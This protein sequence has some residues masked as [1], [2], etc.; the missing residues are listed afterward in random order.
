MPRM[1]SRLQIVV[2]VASAM[3]AGAAFFGCGSSKSRSSGGNGG[4]A[5]TDGSTQGSGGATGTGATTANGGV[6]G[7]GSGGIGSGGFGGIAVG[8]T[9][10]D[11]AVNGGAGGNVGVGGSVS[12][13]SGGSAGS[14]GATAANSCAVNGPCSPSAPPCSS[15][16]KGGTVQYACQ[17]TLKG[18]GQGYWNCG[19][20]LPCGSGNYGPSGSTC[21]PRFQTTGTYCD[22]AGTK[23]SC[24]CQ[25]S[26]SPQPGVWVCSP[27][28][29]TCGVACGARTCLEGEICVSLGQYSGTDAGSSAPTLTSICAAI[30]DACAGTTPSCSACIISAFGCG[31]PGTCRDVSPQ[32]FECI[33]GGA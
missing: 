4:A 30:P 9:G 28:L 20:V 2:A 29:G 21:D 12:P 32:S 5:G 33:L 15:C 8:G 7:T 1:A 22:S 23:Q 27:G 18:A 10:S 16:A 26:T 6:T 24:I 3:V 31:P 11:G 13:G 17:C 25:A 14:G 19:G